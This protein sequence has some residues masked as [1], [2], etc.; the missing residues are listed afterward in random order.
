MAATIAR[1]LADLP[2]RPPTPPKD[3]K[4]G[5]D[6][7]SSSTYGSGKILK[8]FQAVNSYL[9][10]PEDS[11][12]S[13]PGTPLFSASKGAKRVDFSP[14]IDYHGH[15]QTLTPESST[16]QPLRPLP[17]SNSSKS[18]K[19]ILKPFEYISI[20]VSLDG[21]A[22]EALKD[23]P[24][25]LENICRALASSSKTARFDAYETL[26]KCLKTY[27]DLPNHNILASKM[28]LLIDFISRDQDTQGDD[29]DT[30]VM[31]LRSSATKLLLT[32]LG[33][34]PVAQMLTEQYRASV[35][36]KAIRIVEEHTTSRQIM[37]QNLKL[38]SMSWYKSK[39]MTEGRA[40]RLFSAL[41]SI[42]ERCKGNATTLLRLV[43]Y[44]QLLHTARA[45]MVSRAEEWMDHLFVGMLSSRPDV[46]SHAAIFGA[47]AARLMGTK[48][49]V[50]KAVKHMFNRLSPT[51]TPFSQIVFKR[52]NEMIKSRDE[53]LIVP[54]IWAV[55][56]VFL[57][58]QKNQIERWEHCKEWM[59]I[60]QLCFN[61][62]DPELKNQ[63]LHAWN[64]LIASVLRS[65]TDSSMRKM[66]REPIRAALERVTGNPSA[67]SKSLYVASSAYTTL[68]Y[69]G[70]QPGQSTDQ[71]L[72]VWDEYILDIKV[73]PSDLTSR[74]LSQL[75]THSPSKPWDNELA[76]DENA[77]Q[78]QDFPCLEPKWV[79][80]NAHQ[81]VHVVNQM[82]LSN[83]MLLN[84]PVWEEASDFE[85]P[86][87]IQ[88]WESFT[89]SIGEAGR[90]EVKV[91][92][93]CQGAVVEI[94]ELLRSFSPLRFSHEN[95]TTSYSQTNPAKLVRLIRIATSH[96]G[97]LPLTERLIAGGKWNNIF[98]GNGLVQ[99][100]KALPSRDKTAIWWLLDI[101]V[102]CVAQSSPDQEVVRC[103]WE[104]LSLQLEAAT[105]R[106]AKLAF[107]VTLTPITSNST[108]DKL[109][110]QALWQ[111]AVCQLCRALEPSSK[112]VDDIRF[113]QDFSI[114]LTL[115]REG[116][117]NRFEPASSWRDVINSLT[118]IIRQK[119][120]P[121]AVIPVLLEPLTS[122][123]S[124]SIDCL[125][126]QDFIF[127]NEILTAL[128]SHVF[129]YSSP[130]SFLDCQKKHAQVH[131]VEQHLE[132]PNKLIYKAMN[133]SLERM[134]RFAKA[135]KKIFQDYHLDLES[136]LQLTV[137][138]YGKCL[139]NFL[140]KLLGGSVGL[141]GWFQSPSAYPRGLDLVRSAWRA[142][143]EAVRKIL[144]YDSGTAHELSNMLCM[145]LLSQDALITSE[146]V[147]L[148]NETFGRTHSLSLPEMIKSIV[149]PPECEALTWSRYHAELAPALRIGIEPE[150]QTSCVKLIVLDDSSSAD[151]APADE[152]QEEG[153]ALEDMIIDT[154]MKTEAL[155]NHVEELAKLNRTTPDPPLVPLTIRTTPRRRL[156]HEDSQ[157]E[158][159]AIDSS[160]RDT[161]AMASQLLTEHQREIRNRQRT[162]AEAMFPEIRSSPK[163]KSSPRETAFRLHGSAARVNSTAVERRLHEHS[164]PLLPPTKD[165]IDNVIGSSPTPRSGRSRQISHLADKIP[166]SSPLKHLEQTTPSKEFDRFPLFSDLASPES[167][168]ARKPFT[169]LKDIFDQEIE[170]DDDLSDVDSME[171]PV[172]EGLLD[173]DHSGE[174][175]IELPLFA[176]VTQIH[177]DALPDA[178]TPLPSVETNSEFDVF[179]NALPS[180][181][182]A[183]NRSPACFLQPARPCLTQ[184][185]ETTYF[186]NGFP[187]HSVD[188]ALSP[189]P[190][191]GVR[192][193]QLDGSEDIRPREDAC[194]KSSFLDDDFDQ[195]DIEEQ[196]SQQFAFEIQQTRT[197]RGQFATTSTIND[198]Q[199]PELNCHPIEEGGRKR[200][201]AEVEP[202]ATEK[203][204]SPR[205]EKR[206]VEVRI[207]RISSQ[208]MPRPSEEDYDM[209]DCIVVNTTSLSPR[210][211]SLD[212]EL[213]AERVIKSVTGQASPPISAIR[214][215]PR[216]AS[217]K[218]TV[219]RAG[220][221]AS[222]TSSCGRGQ[223]AAVR[224]SARLGGR[225]TPDF[226][227]P[228]SPSPTSRAPDFA[229]LSARTATGPPP[230]GNIF[231]ADNE[232]FTQQQIQ[233]PSVE[234]MKPFEVIPLSPPL[235][236]SQ[237]LWSSFEMHDIGAGNVG[238]ASGQT[239]LLNLREMITRAKSAVVGPGETRELLGAWMDLGRE[240]HNLEP[241]G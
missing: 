178:E 214:G 155:P 90:R 140:P 182:D 42:V 51:G 224:R 52:M 195:S 11:P 185:Y 35:V 160:P 57:R 23:F 80:K 165:M 13:N 152:L 94:L 177:H 93:E 241:R 40:Q 131:R 66:L 20:A 121:C 240:L 4:L 190:V 172:R 30:Q 157:I 144:T 6:S 113:I 24:T 117:D 103:L 3:S 14:W 50:S 27:D 179:T 1:S 187:N 137:D 32:I 175:G 166:T 56:I 81:I 118:K 167:I 158:F 73:A 197:R 132:D 18:V 235:H 62:A 229:A 17:P 19:S 39:S 37:T 128:A 138:V 25:M 59:S 222:A 176:P 43:I 110:R 33:Y 125:E 194:I 48:A 77:I 186:A 60:I 228:S 9:N 145:A 84:F 58:S 161:E 115:L 221:T 180:P 102:N 112:P 146:A 141:G 149:S 130:E 231:Q 21:G 92:A 22:E 170:E 201:R 72:A 129:W 99:A 205:K 69:Y 213:Q 91:S 215:R 216:S 219:S 191:P 239:L 8:S 120:G 106:E 88:F 78:L 217:C 46:R 225:G 148:W 55:P 198:R 127:D 123:L 196:L 223:S 119:L 5:K 133:D 147:V 203:T 143:A 116:I 64:K 134:H 101:L 2:A 220:S 96:I 142:W 49:Q 79:R 139:R 65:G 111:L 47:E 207:Q 15:N 41:Q 68:L 70:F 87:I 107:L 45:M 189:S 38:L 31:Q 208:N 169:R 10:T 89:L 151:K 74:L 153:L 97:E 34:A 173:K 188:V 28:E 109:A 122:C 174:L 36:E 83:R 29:S 202:V 136:I 71:L 12:S 218:T 193:M 126:A 168:L 204:Y 75:I 233:P 162:E 183:S 156:R 238:P 210:Q 212:S 82:L 108:Y 104:L 164:S 154:D 85:K 150:M 98:K 135:D 236:E 100:N 209:L 230:T 232:V 16:K 234:I 7:S 237:A 227:A 86:C 67:K 44:K 159:T 171:F 181:L 54:K 105:S 26:C 61:A 192:S 53:R 184:T 63:A 226:V 199:T 114:A 95:A 206:K 76:L 200:K 163:S 124:R 211:P